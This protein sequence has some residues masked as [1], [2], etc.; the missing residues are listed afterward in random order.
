MPWDFSFTEVLAGR[1]Q[2]SPSYAGEEERQAP[3]HK[4]YLSR[5]IIEPCLTK[6]NVQPIAAAFESP[7]AW[8]RLPSYA[9]LT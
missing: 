2:T 5:N 1:D 7:I 8:P 4:A 3:C 6:H 9:G